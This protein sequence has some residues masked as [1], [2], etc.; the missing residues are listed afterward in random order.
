MQ[1]QVAVV[2]CVL[3][4]EAKS[5]LSIPIAQPVPGCISIQVIPF[6]HAYSQTVNVVLSNGNCLFRALQLRL[7]LQFS[8]GHITLE[9]LFVVFVESTYKHFRC[10]CNGTLESDCARMRNALTFCTQAELQAA[11]LFQFFAYVYSL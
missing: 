10:L 9:E 8:S 11:S 4:D 3:T 7:Y 1:I 6:P 2:V 5:G